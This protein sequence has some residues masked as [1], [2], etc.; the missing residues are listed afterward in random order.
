[1]PSVKIG[2]SEGLA[3][4]VRNLPLDDFWLWTIIILGVGLACGYGI[5]HFM[6]R[7]RIIEDTPTSK[8]RS[9]SQGYVE[10]IGTIKYLA[11]QPIQAPLTNKD[12]AWYSYKIEKK[13]HTYTGKTSTTKWKII[14]QEISERPFQCADDS[15]TCM[16]NPK[17]AEVYPSDDNTWYGNAKWPAG[18]PTNNT[19]IFSSGNY[20]YTEER[21]YANDPLYAIGLFHTVDPNKA[22]G[23]ASNEV[24]AVLSAWKQDQ[25]TL[26]ERFDENQDGHI[27]EREW[28]GARL[29]AHAYVYEQR[30]KRADR[31]AIN[32]MTATDDYRRPYILSVK[33]PL[34]MSKSFRLKAAGCTL[35]FVVCAPLSAWML[36]VRL[37]G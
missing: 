26:H 24:R 17:A 35:G 28:D 2:P 37:A 9:A 25:T 15:G 13:V 36:F 29:A 18:G 5:F 19:S 30:L 32:I 11:D 3:D 1:M 10:I 33:P 21:L 23:D 34:Q 12:C 14:K 16:I 31:P 27:D 7:A 4:N 6:R 22:H 20:R 8:I